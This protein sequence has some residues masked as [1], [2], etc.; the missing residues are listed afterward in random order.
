M[1][2]A[3]IVLF[4]LAAVPLYAAPPVGHPSTGQAARTLQLP[5]GD[6]LPYQGKVLQAIN[7]ND[8]TYIEIASEEG[9][10]W[11]AA[12]RVTLKKGAIIRFGEGTLMRDFYSKKLKRTFAAVLFVS[13]VTP[14][15][16][17]K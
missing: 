3:I 1:R 13:I 8:Y 17:K 16:K 2:Y 4:G 9:Q 5:Q 6:A 14:V 15:G 10:R 11:L 12:P 7:S